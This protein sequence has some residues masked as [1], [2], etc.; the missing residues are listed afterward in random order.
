MRSVMVSGT[1]SCKRS[2]IP[3]VP[4]IV[5]SFSMISAAAMS[6]CRLFSVAKRALFQQFSA[7]SSNSSFGISRYAK[8]SVRNPLTAKSSAACL[9][10]AADAVLIFA[11]GKMDSSAP[12][13]QKYFE[14]KKEFSTQ[15]NYLFLS[16]SLSLSFTIKR[17]GTFDEQADCPIGHSDDNRHPTTV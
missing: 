13:F 9:A 1:A 14:R 3:V 6:C 5:R 4:M 15:I 10:F 16:L 12:R 7:Q 11:R 2:S 17:E 8:M